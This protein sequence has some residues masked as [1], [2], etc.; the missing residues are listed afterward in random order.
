MSALTPAC[1]SVQIGRN[2]S[3]IVTCNRRKVSD[4]LSA[5]E[6]NAMAEKFDPA[7]TDKH[8]ETVKARSAAPKWRTIN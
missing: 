7:P 3:A 1:C 4:A 6:N 8:A 2:G 5:V